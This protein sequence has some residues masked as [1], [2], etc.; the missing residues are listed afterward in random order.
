MYYADLDLNPIDH[1]TYVPMLPKKPLRYEIFGNAR[2]GIGSMQHPR[3]P[4]KNKFVPQEGY[5]HAP[6]FHEDSVTRF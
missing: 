1:E 3:Y 6:L 4:L 2:N 5:G